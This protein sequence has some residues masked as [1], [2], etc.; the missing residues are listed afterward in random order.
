ML[1]SSGASRRRALAGLA[2]ASTLLLA[3]RSPAQ[4]NGP[5]VAHAQGLTTLPAPPKRVAVLDLAA[6]DILQAL[7]IAPVGVPKVNFPP[8]LAAY[9]DDAFPKIGT[10]F[11]PDDEA[12]RAAQP[13]LIINAGRSANKYAA[14]S[15]IAP[16]IDLSSSTQG[17]VASVARNI[18]L[19][20]RLFDRQAQAAARAEQLLAN[21]RALQDK[22][23]RA[24][25]GLLLFA[26]GNGLAPQA[27][28]TR[29][30][31]V[32]EVAGITP[33]M[34]A[35]DQPPARARARQPQAPA[36]GTPEAAAAEAARARQ[37]QEQA[38]RLARLLARDPDWLFVL[39]RPSATGGE[40][41]APD[42]LAANAAIAQTTAWKKQQ[43]IH[44]DAPGW[45]LVGG[46]PTMLENSMASIRAAFDGKPAA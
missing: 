44:L 7:G 14:L 25:K 3:G 12:L 40:P 41:I 18:L 38:E 36:E 16:T 39:D 4:G 9:G 13:D 11:E 26:V 20:G 29:F 5:G 43:V 45:Y 46:G 34:A 32:Y 31:I 1:P 27:P 6:L 10:L 22:G 28:Q 30:G 8:Y 35:A 42:L 19:L 23:A 33:L 24:G 17:F 2:G 21:A 37:S 15:R